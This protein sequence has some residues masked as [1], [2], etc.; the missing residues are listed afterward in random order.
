[1]EGTQVGLPGHDPARDEVPKPQST[2]T[3]DRRGARNIDLGRNWHVEE[4][5][6]LPMVRRA[7]EF[8]RSAHD[9]PWARFGH[10]VGTTPVEDRLPEAPKHSD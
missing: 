8:I 5:G 1:M 3:R 10:V 9:G 2:F 6:P 7:W 4:T